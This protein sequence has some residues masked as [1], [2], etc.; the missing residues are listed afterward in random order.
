MAITRSH[1]SV[2]DVNPFWWILALRGAF[3]LLFGIVLLVTKLLLGTIFFDPIL[4]VLVSLFLGF[5][6][7]AN[8]I[9]FVCA[10][11]LS[12]ERQQRIW[13]PLSIHAVVAI[14]VGFCIAELLML[15]RRSADVVAST[16]IFCA[17]LLQL[18]VL[19][20]EK[21]DPVLRTVAAAFALASFELAYCLF[22]HQAFPVSTYIGILATY[23]GVFGLVF[24]FCAWRIHARMLS[25][26]SLKV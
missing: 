14:L 15:T 7:V 6:V 19:F 16:Y 23:E 22:R 10:A 2:V 5:Y 13:L 12:F 25:S 17:A 24:L 21:R 26:W 9:L 1:S 4:S 11:R 8:G 20:R 18:G 3:S